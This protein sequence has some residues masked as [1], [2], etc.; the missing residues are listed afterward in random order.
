MSKLAEPSKSVTS[1]L[2]EQSRA[3]RRALQ[4]TVSLTTVAAGQR[5]NDLLPTWRWSIGRSPS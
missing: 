2:A 1:T 3:R 4:G 5:W